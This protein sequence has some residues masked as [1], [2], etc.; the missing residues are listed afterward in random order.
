LRT[1]LAV[2]INLKRHIT[3]YLR[4]RYRQFPK[5]RREIDTRQLLLYFGQL[6]VGESHT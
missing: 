1:T 6:V 5:P 4:R 3:F 2:G